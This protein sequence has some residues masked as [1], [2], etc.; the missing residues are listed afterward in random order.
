MAKKII[1]PPM[2]T[3]I[4]SPN[5][6]AGNK[7]KEIKTVKDIIMPPVAKKKTETK[8]VY[9]PV[10]PPKASA[11]QNKKSAP[12]L[13]QVKQMKTEAQKFVTGAK[14]EGKKKAEDKIMSGQILPGD[15]IKPS[16][17]SKIKNMAKD[18]KTQV[19][20]FGTGMGEVFANPIQRAAYEIN[21]AFGIKNRSVYNNGSKGEYLSLMGKY[22]K[23]KEEGKELSNEE[24]DRLV[25]LQK[26]QDME[27]RQ[28]L[29]LRINGKDEDWEKVE[30]A[31]QLGAFAGEMFK[32]WIGGELLNAFVAGSG[33]VANGGKI[34]KTI[35][36]ILTSSANFAASGA[37]SAYGQGA[38]GK[39]IAKEAVKQGVLGATAGIVSNVTKAGGTKLLS[40]AGISTDLIFGNQAARIGLN[41]ISNAAGMTA[42]TF[43]ASKIT[44]DEATL[45]DYL[46][47]AVMAIVFTG[48]G[49]LKTQLSRN[50]QTGKTMFSTIKEIR[51][52]SN[53]AIEN[54]KAQSLQRVE[55]FWRKYLSEPSKKTYNELINQINIEIKY[56]ETIASA[57][58]YGENE[59]L[60]SKGGKVL[61]E[62]YQNYFKF[63]D[64][65]PS[66]SADSF[67]TGSGATTPAG[68]SNT[69]IMPPK[70]INNGTVIMPPKSTNS[71]NVIMPPKALNS[72]GNSGT[73]KTIG[74]VTNDKSTAMLENDRRFNEV[75]TGERQNPVQAEEYRVTPGE[76]R[77]IEVD[78][79]RRSFVEERTIEAIIDTPEFRKISKFVGNELSEKQSIEMFAKYV[80]DDRIEEGYDF[81][82]VLAYDILSDESNELREIFKDSIDEYFNTDKFSLDIDSTGAKIDEEVLK[83]TSESVVR[84]SNGQLIPVYHG[85]DANY[86]VLLPGDIGIHFGSYSQAA[87]LVRGKEITSPVFIKAYLNIRNPI[88]V[89]HDLNG[90]N[91]AQMVNVLEEKGIIDRDT[92]RSIFSK[93]I[94]NEEN[95]KLVDLLKSKGYDGIIYTNEYESGM[96]TSYIVFN[97]SQVF[98]TN[99]DSIIE[100]RINDQIRGTNNV[101]MPQN[102]NND[103]Y[104][105][106][107][108][109][110]EPQGR[111]NGDGKEQGWRQSESPDSVRP[112]SNQF[113]F[114]ARTGNEAGGWPKTY[115]RVRGTAKKTAR[116]FIKT[117][118]STITF[119]EY[120]N[121]P[122][123]KK[124]FK[125]KYN[126]D[127]HFAKGTIYAIDDIDETKHPF[128]ASAVYVGGNIIVTLSKE[129][130]SDVVH[131]MVHEDQGSL[132]YTTTVAEI[133]KL[134]DGEKT[135]DFYENKQSVYANVYEN[136]SEFVEDVEKEVY[137]DIISVLATKEGISAEKVRN[138][139]PDTQSYE[140]AKD[141]AANYLMHLINNP[142]E[143]KAVLPIEGSWLN[144]DKSPFSVGEVPYYANMSG[145]EITA[146]ISDLS[147][148]Q[149]RTVQESEEL[150]GLLYEKFG[151]DNGEY[152]TLRHDIVDPIYSTKSDE[153][154]EDTVNQLISSE[155]YL[156][157]LKTEATKIKN[158]LSPTPKQMEFIDK[159]ASGEAT[160]ED[161]SVSVGLRKFEK[162]IEARAKV[163]AVEREGIKRFKEDSR[164]KF[165]SV[166]EDFIRDSDDWSDKTAIGWQIN[167]PER[168]AY[169]T[170]GKDAD[171][172]IDTFI[173][174]M[175]QNEA[176]KIRYI[177]E[178]K[179]KLASLQLTDEE[180][181]QTM[182]YGEGLLID[183]PDKII[184]AA[185]VFNEVAEQIKNDVNATLVLNGYKPIDNPKINL[186]ANEFRDAVRV[187]NGEADILN[188]TSNKIRQFINIAQRNGIDSI[189]YDKKGK[190]TA[191][192]SIPY[193]PHGEV[194]TDLQ[195]V[196]KALGFSNE[197]TELPG[198]ITGQTENFKPNKK[199]VGNLEKRRGKK[200]DYD[201]RLWDNYINNI[202]EVIYHT[203]DITKL[204]LL[205]S[206]LRTKYSQSAIDKEV[207]ETRYMMTNEE[208][209]DWFAALDK[210]TGQLTKHNNLINWLNEYANLI[211]GKRHSLDR[212]FEKSVMG[213]RFYNLMTNAESNWAAN[214]VGGNVSSVINQFS[215]MTN[216]MAEKN[217][218][219]V[220]TALNTMLFGDT[221]VLNESDFITTREG[222]IKLKE[223]RIQKIAGMLF[224]APM[225]AEGFT[226]R[227]VWQ[228]AYNEAIRKGKT[229][230]EARAEADKYAAQIMAGRTKI[231]APTIFSSKQPLAKIFTTFQIEPANTFYHYI[232]DLP[233]EA[234]GR[235]VMW[236]IKSAI[237]T[238][239]LN[240]LF[241]K[242]KEW[243]T[244]SDNK[245]TLDPFDTA[246][247]A[248]K[249]FADEEGLELDDVLGSIKENVANLPFMQTTM[250]IFGFN[251]VGQIPMSNMVPNFPDIK[252]KYQNGKYASAAW[253]AADAVISPFN[254][255]GGYAQAKKTI[256]GLGTV[257]RGGEYDYQGNLM[258]PVEQTPGNYIKGALFGKSAFEG[259][260]AYW[261][262]DRRALTENETGEY[263]WRIERGEDPQAVYD[264]IIGRKDANSQTSADNAKYKEE[265][266]NIINPLEDDLIY[267][268]EEIYR[269]YKKTNPN[270]TTIGVPQASKTFSY[271]GKQYELT[272]EQYAQ[273]Q[274]MY[275]EEYANAVG[276]I[277]S[278]DMSVEDKYTQIYERRKAVSS[279]VKDRFATEVLQVE[280]NKT[281]KDTDYY[282]KY[283]QPQETTKKTFKDTE[284]YKKYVQPQ[285]TTKKSFKDTEYYKKYMSNQTS[286]N[287]YGGGLSFENYK[288]TNYNDGNHKGMDFATP[289]GTKVQSTVAGEVVVAQTLKDSYGKYVVIKDASDN[290]HYFAHL[291]GYNVKVGDRV[292]KGTLI[293]YSGNTGNSSGPHL[294]YEVRRGNNYAAQI[295][296]KVF[297]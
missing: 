147:S 272:P 269:E 204:R 131:E 30:T 92:A 31:E 287:G 151:K 10:M 87:E 255:I 284:Y 194:L 168:N 7:I 133:T 231:D 134:F 122:T 22:N 77:D 93:G 253:D 52:D 121:V 106:R 164:W 220:I 265:A 29:G 278:S 245:V 17:G 264:D 116:N 101:A 230:K 94:S 292:G 227:L 127:V 290:Y 88:V 63:R 56:L 13:P 289:I 86:P 117:Y 141:L 23:A 234:K 145:D 57:N 216:L 118:N 85:T 78:G 195:S 241:N 49:E 148:R 47:A 103:I 98:R 132:Q 160:L 233:R 44:G 126:R 232:K 67:I 213:R 3:E 42:G 156:Y 268:P 193:F 285:E 177:N 128:E 59:F 20:A 60:T 185:K 166:I 1:M 19:R 214:Q 21:Q 152:I 219:D 262:N 250:A 277:I 91:A 45:N 36:G 64:F 155:K 107:R 182:K 83:L 174:P 144:V 120:E 41:A 114:G 113:Y 149:A 79:I 136:R 169:D 55:G 76:Y 223:G 217:P 206:G 25:F 138:L 115:G 66:N 279:Q 26:D 90:W 179:E 50:P 240:H 65:V 229:D 208:L 162:L 104:Y 244:G 199:W 163:F 125:D 251:D 68:A 176:Q 256:K 200:T 260:Q 129:A 15:A 207:R 171:K 96:G 12:E 175:K 209:E 130:E 100:K 237:A 74:G 157:E 173:T 188:M 43:A 58:V 119:E 24:M 293:G 275:N 9:G 271:D 254:P 225:A 203:G 296:P 261:D 51:L 189:N 282:K 150:V 124:Y 99:N 82:E 267:G 81:S 89:E 69:V 14:V 84:N 111:N 70:A 109:T 165:Q 137:A 170:M 108:V 75:Q 105:Q 198:E 224:K 39:Q 161:F 235:G 249:Y 191:S 257:I 286:Y 273:L 252:K 181:E 192:V 27:K 71:G 294:H 4:S 228:T 246:Y 18:A 283:V 97:D 259:N 73:I 211:S 135:A 205:E 110:D 270:A 226:S 143:H 196:K 142:P 263:H 190:V 40:R 172:F 28:Y 2:A 32:L 242:G 153:S 6:L 239:L 236:L 274:N 16:A 247:T 159:I 183:A 238:V 291:D 201:I 243:L 8:E 276:D 197:V 11:V 266:G 210:K 35:A 34:T 53:K 61:K 139:F 72:F 80:E 38:S 146:R 33:V 5:P 180:F 54:F 212:G 178:L 186:N 248:Y 184:H 140:K 215:Q 95:K 112:E 37:T 280:K 154:I 221:S 258:Y 167:T 62:L 158:A 187:L 222:T 202:S 123:A 102:N 46:T 288:V 297:L 48:Y 218:V 295:N 281:F